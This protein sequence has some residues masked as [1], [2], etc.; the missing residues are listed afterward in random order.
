VSNVTD[1]VGAVT[2]LS[3]LLS[4]H[5]TTID[6]IEVIPVASTAGDIRCPPARSLASPTKAPIEGVVFSTC[7]ALSS[8]AV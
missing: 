7:V 6:T 5:S 2:L 4:R 8:S 1:E 3:F